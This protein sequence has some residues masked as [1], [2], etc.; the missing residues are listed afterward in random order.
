[1]RLVAAAYCAVDR[2]IAQSSWTTAIR[3]WWR[4]SMPSGGLICSCIYPSPKPSRM[5]NLVKLA[6]SSQSLFFFRLV[7]QMDPPALASRRLPSSTRS[8]ILHLL[9]NMF[10][11]SRHTWLL[12]LSLYHASWHKNAEQIS[13]SGLGALESQL[14]HL[15]SG[16]EKRRSL[17]RHGHTEQDHPAQQ[18]TT[19]LG[20]I[21][22]LE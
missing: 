4:T 18:G 7:P 1:M 13:F 21:P 3:R 5:V 15:Q 10:F 20:F 6:G 11:A 9:R 12:V 2:S 19:S 17:D 8:H 22:H 14:A 16:N